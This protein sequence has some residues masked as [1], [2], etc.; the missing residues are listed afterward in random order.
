[1]SFERGTLSASV[2]SRGE[3]VFLL[4]FT[5]G[6]ITGKNLVHNTKKSVKISK[7]IFKILENP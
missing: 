6:Q 5:E 3:E 4:D 7:K 1:M 2:M